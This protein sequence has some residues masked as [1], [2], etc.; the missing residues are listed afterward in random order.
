MHCSAKDGEL[1][2]S[3]EGFNMLY[4]WLGSSWG[5]LLNAALDLGR[6]ANAEEASQESG[7]LISV[8]RQASRQLPD[9]YSGI[10]DLLAFN[11]IHKTDKW[12]DTVHNMNNATQLWEMSVIVYLGSRR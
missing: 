12:K 6:Q 11:G 8:E 3:K 9:D 10:P 5:D 4:R 7:M 1:Q 2:R